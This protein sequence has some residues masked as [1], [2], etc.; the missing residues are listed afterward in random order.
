MTVIIIDGKINWT[1]GRGPVASSTGL[2]AGASHTPSQSNLEAG[3]SVSTTKCLL[4]VIP[5]IA[6][7]GARG[8]W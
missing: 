5:V 7:R 1:P 4:P 8:M 3:K 2:A 6:R